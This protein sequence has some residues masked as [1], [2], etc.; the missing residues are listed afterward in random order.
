MKAVFQLWLSKA[1]WSTTLWLT[2]G[3]LVGGLTIDL[4]HHAGDRGVLLNRIW[5]YLV[6]NALM[7]L[8]ACFLGST[9]VSLILNRGTTSTKQTPPKT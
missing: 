2:G 5:F 1:W 3:G 9:V 6:Q 8:T 4:T 7:S